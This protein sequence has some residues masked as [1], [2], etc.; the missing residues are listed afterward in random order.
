[1]AVHGGGCSWGQTISLKFS[2]THLLGVKVVERS[3]SLSDGGSAISLVWGSAAPS[4]SISCRLWWQHDTIS[5]AIVISIS[6]KSLLWQH[7]NLSLMV[8]VLL[9]TLSCSDSMI[10]ISL[11]MISL[12]LTAW[13][14]SLSCSGCVIAISIAQWQQD[15]NL[16]L[17]VAAW[18]LSLACVHKWQ[19]NKLWSLSHHNFLYTQDSS[20]V[21]TFLVMLKLYR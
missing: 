1:M 10:V 14:W 7:H 4:L 15:H 3:D 19:Q 17:V 13:L 6:S 12:A 11:I 9:Q 8:A 21:V 20:C 5:L 16:S 18:L 2:L